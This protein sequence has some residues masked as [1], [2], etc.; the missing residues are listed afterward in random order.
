MK[1]I[2]PAIFHKDEDGKYRGYFPDLEDCFAQGDT[3]DDAIE[4]ANEAACNWISIELEEGGHLLPS[5]SDIEDLTLKEGEIVRNIAA[6]IRL[7][8]GYDE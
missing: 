7:F 8:E 1:F 2:Y 5:V 4:D 3:L 6:N